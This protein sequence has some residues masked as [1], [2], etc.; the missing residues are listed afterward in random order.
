M[1][2]KQESQFSMFRAVES[3]LDGNPEIVATAPAFQTS[4]IHFKTKIVAI[5][6]AMQKEDLVTKGITV[7]KSETKKEL[8]K[9]A[10]DVAGPIFAYASSTNNSQL[11]K[12]VGFSYSKLLQTK[13]DGLAPRVKNIHA[14]G[15]ENLENLAPYGITAQTLN[16]LL[17]M[18]ESYMLKVPNPR[19]ASASKKTTRE[20]IKTM[21][22]E[23]NAILKD[24]MDKSIVILKKSHPNFV[25]TYTANRV[26]IDPAKGQTQLK[27]KVT[28]SITKEPIE[29]VTI[30][31]DNF[32]ATTDA[33]GKYQIGNMRLG[34]Y[35]LEATA[36]GFEKIVIPSLAIKQGQI[37]VFNITLMQEA[38]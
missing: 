33:K 31:I 2:A 5:A 8:C 27:G 1:N 19:N 29:S 12:E 6:E 14:A 20:N 36:S 18:I 38:E 25:S 7:N 13:D 11:Q 17:Q 32:T 35:S 30:I 26:I 23:T 4:F 22:N 10:S 24:Q 3:H 21:M 34:T 16:M 28:N 15:I 37:N 9:F